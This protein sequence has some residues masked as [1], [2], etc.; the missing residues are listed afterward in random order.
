MS[1]GS[2]VE[3]PGRFGMGFQKQHVMTELTMTMFRITYINLDDSISF[4]G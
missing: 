3:R 1:A 4:C 2:K